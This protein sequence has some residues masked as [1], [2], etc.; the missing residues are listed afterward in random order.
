MAGGGDAMVTLVDGHFRPVPFRQM[1]DPETGRTRVR[2]VDITSEHY[3]I[4]R[5]YMV[6]LRSEDFEDEALLA[7]LAA[8]AN[9]TPQAFKEQF[10]YVVENEVPLLDLKVSAA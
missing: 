8:T 4:A 2:L 5:R 3:K 10:C 7:R 6:R 1:L 9:L